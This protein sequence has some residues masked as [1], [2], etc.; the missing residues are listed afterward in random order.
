M[1]LVA[2][3]LPLCA[4]FQLFDAL[5]AAC[6]GLLRGLGMQ[7]IGGYVNLPC[8]YV[9]AMP[10]SFGTAF[11]LGWGLYGLWSGVALA[12]GLVAAIEGIFLYRAN[13]ERAVKYAQH[14]N[15]NA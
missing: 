2:N 6:N 8:Y 5:A 13:W 10:V 11:K 3:I 15:D 7:E 4:A 1:D 9:V 12:L 14:R